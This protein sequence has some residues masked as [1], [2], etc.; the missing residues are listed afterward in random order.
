VFDFELESLAK[1]GVDAFSEDESSSV[2][3]EA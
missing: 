3:L 1:K 2:L